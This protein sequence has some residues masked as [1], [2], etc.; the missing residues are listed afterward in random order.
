MRRA[1]RERKCFAL[2]KW[3]CALCA[4]MVCA[5]CLFSACGGKQDT[6]FSQPAQGGAPA[7]PPAASVPVVSAPTASS[8]QSG[9]EHPFGGG[10]LMMHVIEHFK[11][12]KHKG[13][14]A[15]KLSHD[16]LQAGEMVKQTAEDK[17]A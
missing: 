14:H 16:H 10:S 11:A 5:V 7:N 9:V 17:T 1:D 12:V 15:S 8:T 6:P 4:L 2:K 13:I 3:F